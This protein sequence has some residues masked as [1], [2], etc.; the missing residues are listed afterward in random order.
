MTRPYNFS[1]GPATLPEEVLR[2]A[3]AEMLD[4]KGTGISVME[5]SH[6]SKEFISIAEAAETD[7]RE[8]LA[9]PANYK[10][11]FLQGG[12]MGQFA[13]VPMNLLAGKDSADY[14]VTGYWSKKAMDEAKSYC[15]PNLAASS[16]GSGFTS[17]VKQEDWTVSKD[18][19][20]LHY[21][22]N[23][24]IHG[25]EFPYIPESDTP[26]VVD[27]SSNILSRRF[28]VE[29]FGLIYAGA[30][31]NIG[32]AGLTLV[33]VRDDLIG[34]ALPVTPSVFNYKSQ[35]ES[36]SMLNT[37]PTYSWYVAGLTFKWLKVLGGVEAMEEINKRKAD[38]LYEAIDN[39]KNFF[40]NVEKPYRSRM[41]IPFLLKDKSLEKR[42]MAEAEERGL[43]SLAG[44][45]SV[46]GM[47]ASLYN[48]MSEAGV[49]ALS[50]FILEFDKTV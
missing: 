45:R 24:T 37:P 25:V 35:S 9:I 5:M 44:H 3:Q 4:W 27:M 13:A 2:E 23:E 46:G 28:K 7:L 47:R 36:G 11:L 6:R 48:A 17:I 34:E 21:T 50:D 38:T 32:P 14:V 30:Q 26:L 40:N 41:N 1:A 43:L 8:L 12:A 19:A 20:Y 15:R 33:I 49:K 10:I 22:D 16:Q 39:S 31:K 29:N 42:F 18:S